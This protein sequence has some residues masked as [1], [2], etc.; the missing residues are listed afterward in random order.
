MKR[1]NC[2]AVCTLC[3]IAVGA[4]LPV[5]AE[6]GK[7]TTIQGTKDG[8]SQG[9]NKNNN[10]NNQSSNGSSGDNGNNQANPPDQ[11]RRQAAEAILQQIWNA[12]PGQ[13][14]FNAIN[15]V[16]KSY[17]ASDAATKDAIVSL[18]LTYMKD[19]SRGVLD[20]WPCCY[21]L[22][23]AA[24]QQAVPDLIDVL[25]KDEV[26]TMRAV[27]AEALGFM[28]S[29]NSSTTIRDALVQASKTDSS[30][31]VL[32]TIAKYIGKDMINPGPG[33]PDE[34]HRK[35]AEAILQ[36]IWRAQPGQPK[37]DAINAVVQKIRTG[38]AA[39]KSAVIWLSQMT[40]KDKGRAVLDRWPCCYVLSR[41]P[42][43]Q[44]VPDL[45]DLLRND[46]VEAMRAVAAESLGELY[47]SG[48]DKTI[49]DALVDAYNNDSSKW[50][51]DTIAKY[52]NPKR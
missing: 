44:A 22:S 27:A 18:C 21:V 49:R 16:V 2:I 30:K 9:N 39:T 47:N 43:R 6:R 41:T 29:Q 28:Y 35:A 8:D 17:K 13:S 48:A 46:E 42:Y 34:E 7:Y 20:R 14:K 31:W 26:E 4:V 40:M 23:F 51:R 24:Y 52:I 37:F 11:S 36:Q 25:L 19:T 15:R 32:D 5:H 1:I 12:G 50:V 3:L 38:D 45:I 33:A 10:S